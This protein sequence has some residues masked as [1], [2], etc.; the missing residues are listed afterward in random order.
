MKERFYMFKR[1]GVYYAEDAATGRQ[2]SLK[3]KDAA[4]ARRIVHAKNEAARC[5]TLNLMMARAYL[6]AHD[7]K[8]LE[9]TWQDAMDEFCS[10]GK[11]QTQEHR[12]RVDRF[13][14]PQ[15]CCAAT[16]S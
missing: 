6:S 2:Q 4:E 1:S 7:P 11:K 16:E 3:T 12:R 13:P 15:R 10:R 9:R 8:V 5:P 14:V